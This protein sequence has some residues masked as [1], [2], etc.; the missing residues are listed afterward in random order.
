MEGGDTC[1]IRPLSAPR[2]LRRCFDEFLQALV[3]NVRRRPLRHL[4]P[5]QVATEFHDE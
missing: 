4:I 2:P 3:I 5:R 1:C